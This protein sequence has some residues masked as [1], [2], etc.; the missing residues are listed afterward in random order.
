[1]LSPMELSLS[2][3]TF[4][5]KRCYVHRSLFPFK[6]I[7]VSIF[8]DTSFQVGTKSEILWSLEEISWKVHHEGSLWRTNFYEHKFF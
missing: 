1:M 5:I 6:L 8:G 7:A 4:T 3:F 2:Y